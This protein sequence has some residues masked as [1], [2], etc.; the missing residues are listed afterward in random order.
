M[1]Y[2]AEVTLNE[3]DSLQDMLNMEKNMVK[4]YGT[5]ITEGCSKGF[6]QLVKSHWSQTVEDQMDV[7]LLMTELDY[8]RV[9]TA[10]KDQ[11]DKQKQVF[12]KVKGQL[13]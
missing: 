12:S 13:S 9:E 8:C 7:F 2:K 11:L 1:D 6:R 4:L 5:A 10:P 3:K